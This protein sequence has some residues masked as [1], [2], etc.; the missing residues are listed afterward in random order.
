MLSHTTQTNKTTKL[1][2]IE[3]A[4]KELQYLTLCC[5]LL[6]RICILLGLRDKN[7][8]QVFFLITHRLF[9][10]KCNNITLNYRH[11]YTSLIA[12]KPLPLAL[13]TLEYKSAGFGAM[14]CFTG[15][16]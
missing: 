9:F 4:L 14:F 11:Q 5:K 16:A 8:S 6:I 2:R 15:F 3:T 10:W 7:R 12:L 1:E 13:S